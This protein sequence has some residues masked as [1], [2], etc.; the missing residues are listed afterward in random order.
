MFM[1]LFLTV[2]KDCQ[3]PFTQTAYRTART[4][5]TCD[6][7]KHQQNWTK[8]FCKENNQTCEDILSGNAFP[9]S[10]GTLTFAKTDSGFNVSINNVSS[11]HEGVYW[12]AVNKGRVRAGL[13]KIHLQVEGEY[14]TC[15]S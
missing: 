8:F 9:E 11:H 6:Y 4:T 12:C 3:G 15:D 7:P 5:I 1:V 10:N 14:Q 2:K 13:K